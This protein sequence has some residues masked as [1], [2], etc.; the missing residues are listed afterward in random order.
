MLYIGSEFTTNLKDNQNKAWAFWS[1]SIALMRD[2]LW[3]DSYSRIKDE[4]QSIMQLHS[5][6]TC[7]AEMNSDHPHLWC[8]KIITAVAPRSTSATDLRKEHR[9]SPPNDPQPSR[10]THER[11]E[12]PE[13]ARDQPQR[14]TARGD[15]DEVLHVSVRRETSVWNQRPQQGAV[16]METLRYGQFRTF[17]DTQLWPEENTPLVRYELNEYNITVSLR[18]LMITFFDT[19]DKISSAIITICRL[20]ETFVLGELIQIYCNIYLNY[21]HSRPKLKRTS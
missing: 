12:D 10:G 19:G 2:Q 7:Y 4:T 1:D 13:V 17:T 6:K 18:S 9:T 5:L 15:D 14:L 11:P 8:G 20:L 3:L 16:H 21:T